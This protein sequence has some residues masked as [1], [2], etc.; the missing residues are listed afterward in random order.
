M[1]ETK[2]SEEDLRDWRDHPVTRIVIAAMQMRVNE[3]EESVK[4][5]MFQTGKDCEDRLVVIAAHRILENLREATSEGLN[6]EARPST[7]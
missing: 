7:A 4:E 6:N 3:L 1:Q 2:I 5:Q